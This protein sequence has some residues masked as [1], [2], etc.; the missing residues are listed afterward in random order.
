VAPGSRL[1]LDVQFTNH[2]PDAVT[3]RVEPLLP[4]GWAWDAERGAPEVSVPA[5]TQGSVDTYCQRPDVAA[6]LWI[7]VSE[8]AAPGLFVLPVRVTWDDRYL[9]PFRHG[10]VRV[11]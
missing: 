3:A 11:R 4:E 7:T 5:R 1:A 6:R 9:G 10:L 2:G 8:D